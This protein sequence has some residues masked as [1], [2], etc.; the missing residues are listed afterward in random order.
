MG[1]LYFVEENLRARRFLSFLLNLEL[2]CHW[3][4]CPA[5]IISASGSNAA[6]LSGCYVRM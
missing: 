2:N 1:N 6:I 4:T 5:A 3:F